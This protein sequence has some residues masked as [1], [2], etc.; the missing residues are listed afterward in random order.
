LLLINGRQLLRSGRLRRR[1]RPGAQSD[2]KADRQTDE[3]TAVVGDIRMSR[4]GSIRR[5]M[6]GETIAVSVDLT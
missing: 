6:G 4:G 1:L 5:P 3:R 2:K